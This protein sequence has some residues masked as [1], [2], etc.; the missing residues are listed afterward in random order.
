VCEEGV[1]RRVDVVE[2][3]LDA[4][5]DEPAA[6]GDWGIG[7]IGALGHWGIGALGHWG[8]GAL[9]HWGIGARGI[10]ALGHWGLPHGDRLEQE[11]DHPQRALGG[12][13]LAHD[14][15]VLRRLL[16]GERVHGRQ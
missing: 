14:V 5:A 1:R 16:D 9:G 15:H 4:D 12:A 6:L 13:R 7:G 10:G 8:I 2:G 11:E 3:E